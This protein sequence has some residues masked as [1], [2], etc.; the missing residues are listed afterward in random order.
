MRKNRFVFLAAAVI[1]MVSSPSLSYD[2]NQLV[3]GLSAHNAFDSKDEVGAQ[4]EWRGKR[5]DDTMLGVAN[6]SPQIG[7][8]ADWESDIYL[9]A[10]LLYDWNVHER[11]SI[12]PSFSAGLYHHGDDGIDLG[13]VI[14]FRSAIELN[15]MISPDSRIGLNLA[16]ISNFGIY[17]DNPG[18]EIVTVNYSTSY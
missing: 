15:Y 14:E 9:Y 8:L 2:Q 16:H 11:W 4:I 3:F 13:G 17:S 12:V 10:G 6:I 7:L 1:S 18:T 5:F